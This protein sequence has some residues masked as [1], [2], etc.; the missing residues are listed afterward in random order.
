MATAINS[1]LIKKENAYTSSGT[2][3]KA[4]LASLK[5]DGTALS[6]GVKL[7]ITLSSSTSLGSGSTR[8]RTAY[9]Y[10]SS[11]KV[12]GSKLIKDSVTSWSAGNTY[13]TTVP[14]EK[15]VPT[16]SGSFSGCYIRILYSKTN[17]YGGTASCYW[18]GDCKYDG[19]SGVSSGNTFSISYNANATYTVTYNKGTYGTGTNTTATKTQGIDLKL[20]AAVFTRTNYKQTGWASN[21]AGTVKVYDLK[22]VYESDKN[23]TLYPYSTKSR[24]KVIFN[25]QGVSSIKINGNSVSSIKFNG[26]TITL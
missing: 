25:G 14:C 8:T 21:A 22:G 16:S 15:V 7:S 5:K 11:D 9:V 4:T 6:F 17:E 20:K 23:I 26:T 10:D 3:Y 2:Y 18:N 24:Y 12:I 13:T 1:I 19:Q